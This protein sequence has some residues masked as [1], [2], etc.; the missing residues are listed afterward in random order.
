[1]V[2]GYPTSAEICG[3]RDNGCSQSFQRGEILWSATTGAHVS[4]QGG[5]RQAY[6]AA[7]AENGIL[8]YPRSPEICGLRDGGCY[9]SFQRGE[10]L[11]SAT[12]GAV[13]SRSGGIRN[14]YR[15]AGAEN[16]VL[17][18]PVNIEICGL[19]DN[20]CYQSFQ[21]GEILWSATTNAHSTVTGP[22]RT[23]YRTQGAENGALG[24]P[25]TTQTCPTTTQCTQTFQT[26][27]LTWTPTTG[28]R[29]VQR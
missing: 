27:T 10:I 8:G 1:G 9:Q 17:G 3:L 22:I 18:Y 5:I 6:R 15:A 28:V 2:L 19:R 24:Y 14:A 11:W 4:R 20:G 21:N 7:G 25:V 12:T 29:M 16:G 13:I 23:T 26:G